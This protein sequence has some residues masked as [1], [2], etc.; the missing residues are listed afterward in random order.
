MVYGCAA[1]VNIEGVTSSS[2]CISHLGDTALAAGTRPMVP[3]A[4]PHDHAA[5][6]LAEP[7]GAIIVPRI[8][9]KFFP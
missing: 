4:A 1:T 3:A 6:C 5:E 2:A 8:S 7:F 9:F